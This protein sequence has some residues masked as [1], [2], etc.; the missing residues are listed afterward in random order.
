MGKR[1]L[2]R[3]WTAL[4]E[5]HHRRPMLAWMTM[6]CVL[7]FK[8]A[9][10]DSPL[11]PAM[12][13]ISVAL[14]REGPYEYW[15]S[16]SFL[17]LKSQSLSHL[18]RICFFMFSANDQTH[19]LPLRYIYVFELFCFGGCVCVCLCLCVCVCVCLF[20]C[21]CVCVCVPENNRSWGFFPS[22]WVPEYWTR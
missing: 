4:W 3:T 1:M 7:G 12:V 9:P 17:L 10:S 21:V 5:S 6:T 15:D 8:A 16:L 14:G 2:K 19:S 13:S 22:A 11:F 18:G 20:L